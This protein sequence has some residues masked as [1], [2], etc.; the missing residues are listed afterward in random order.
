MVAWQVCGTSANLSKVLRLN[1]GKPCTGANEH[2]RYCRG[3]TYFSHDDASVVSTSYDHAAAAKE[4]SWR[5]CAMENEVCNCTAPHEMVRFGMAK[6][7]GSDECVHTASGP[8]GWSEPKRFD[9]PV[10]C[11]RGTLGVDDPLPG[12]RKRCECGRPG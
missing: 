10:V 2:N 6:C 7:S 8:A 5:K 1:H 3:S 4:L 9:G 12:H 11:T